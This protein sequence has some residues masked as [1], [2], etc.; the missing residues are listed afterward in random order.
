MKTEKQHSKCK[1]TVHLYSFEVDDFMEDRNLEFRLDSVDQILNVE[2]RDQTNMTTRAPCKFISQSS[3]KID[4]EVIT[5]VLRTDIFPHVSKLRVL[6]FSMQIDEWK[7]TAV[8]NS[9]L[10]MKMNEG[11]LHFNMFSFT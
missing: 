4:R 5:V 11:R 9:K 8:G 2:I 1:N 10:I 6:K 3:T 7:N